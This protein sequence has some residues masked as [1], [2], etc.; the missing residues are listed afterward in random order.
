MK[1][2]IEE[3]KAVLKRKMKDMEIKEG[4]RPVTGYSR[5]PRPHTQYMNRGAGGGANGVQNGNGAAH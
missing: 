3:K 1:K 4:I 5:T 2:M